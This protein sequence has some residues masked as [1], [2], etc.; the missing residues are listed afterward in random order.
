MPF[1]GRGAVEGSKN[2]SIPRRKLPWS[3]RPSALHIVE[4]LVIARRLEVHTR[5]A[6][7]WG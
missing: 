4:I 6:H 3:G 5:T 2:E 7:Q 1:E